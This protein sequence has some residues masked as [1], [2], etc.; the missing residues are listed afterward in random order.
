MHALL[1]AWG[2]SR[3]SVNW[4][5]CR[6]PR[7]RACYPRMR[8]QPAG[9]VVPKQAGEVSVTSPRQFWRLG[10]RPNGAKSKPPL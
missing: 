7:E 2:S 1:T 10:Q 9:A 5:T 6:S 8:A 3:P 4:D